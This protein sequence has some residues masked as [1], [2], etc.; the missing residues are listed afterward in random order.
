MKENKL[1]SSGIELFNFSLFF[2]DMSMNRY[3]RTTT[4][5]LSLRFNQDSSRKHSM[6]PFQR[7]KTVVFSCFSACFI[8]ATC[9]GIRIFNVEPFAQKSFLGKINFFVFFFFSNCNF[10]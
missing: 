5:V 7:Y 1:L 4:D 2:P 10:V 9:D 8:C 6:I 3:V